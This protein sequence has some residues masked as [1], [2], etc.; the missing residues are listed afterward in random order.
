MDLTAQMPEELSFYKGDMIDVTEVMDNDFAVGICNG[1]TGQFPIA[2][3]EVL[4]GDVAFINGNIKEKKFGLWKEED[5]NTRSHDVVDDN[6]LT[7]ETSNHFATSTIDNGI[8]ELPTTPYGRVLFSFHAENFNELSIT[9]KQIVKLLRHVDEQWI[10]GELNGQTGIFPASYVEIIIECPKEVAL[11]SEKVS[12]P[13][14]EVTNYN[15]AIT[16][17][18]TITPST[19]TYEENKIEETQSVQHISEE[20]INTQEDNSEP[21]FVNV[22]PVPEEVYVDNTYGLVLF[23]FTSEVDESLVLK[24]G[25]TVT[26]IS[27]V[28]E[29]WY[30]A[31]HDNGII[32]L[33][34]ATYI[35][36]ICEEPKEDLTSLPN[37]ERSNSQVS[38]TSTISTPY[39]PLVKDECH[40]KLSESQAAVVEAIIETN[41]N[42]SDNFINEHIE[43][44]KSEAAIKK[45]IKKPPLKPKPVIK[46]KPVL[47]AKTAKPVLPAKPKVNDGKPTPNLP[48][49]RPTAGPMLRPTSVGAP[50]VQRPASYQ[51][52]IGTINLDNEINDQLEKVK[53]QVSI[54]NQ[55]DASSDGVCE[56]DGVIR[57]ITKKLQPSSR[58]SYNVEPDYDALREVQIGQSA[59]YSEGKSGTLERWNEMGLGPKP[60]PR[61]K[62]PPRPQK[63]TTSKSKRVSFAGSSENLMQ[64]SPG[65]PPSEGKNIHLKLICIVLLCKQAFVMCKEILL[66]CS[67]LTVNCQHP[68]NFWLHVMKR[69]NP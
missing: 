36:Q 33:C 34:P 18:P 65:S 3:V 47:P 64:F 29:N 51:A 13:D 43:S 1:R 26:L 15:E 11:Q 23:D 54:A 68:V 62:A 39:S 44:I 6:D 30:R 31:Q 17:E 53:R 22:E 67:S 7:I 60:V 49:G 61:R 2:F 63:M 46:P 38:Q 66:I 14:N 42:K 19:T 58:K 27:K 52:S 69:V 10:E 41:N 21:N 55:P 48:P 9:E 5:T 16:Q 50:A 59:F 24:K 35:Q 32:G 8:V 25:D 28:D 4:E 12:K 40:G 37:R 57:D 20:A 45:P 56:T